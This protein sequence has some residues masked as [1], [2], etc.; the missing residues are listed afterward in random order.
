MLET[1]QETS[2]PPKFVGASLRHFVT[3]ETT[4]A[5]LPSEWTIQQAT[6][7]IVGAI[8]LPTVGVENRPQHYELFVRRRNGAEEKLNPG[9]TIGEAI[10]DGDELRPMPEVTPGAGGS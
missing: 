1:V 9:A 6:R 7:E 2:L 10:A 4:D 3:D 5:E 8:G